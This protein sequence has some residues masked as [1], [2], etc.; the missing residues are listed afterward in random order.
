MSA[1]SLGTGVT[2]LPG[3]GAISLPI[4]DLA[5]LHHDGGGQFDG[6]TIA[7]LIAVA[8]VLAIIGFAAYA[9]YQRRKQG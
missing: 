3:S 2:F 1:G 8:A 6:G 4:L 5:P 7:I 9:L